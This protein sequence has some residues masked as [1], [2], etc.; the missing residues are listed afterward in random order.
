VGPLTLL[1]IGMS[2]GLLLGAVVARGLLSQQPDLAVAAVDARAA[3]L[4]TPS[5]VLAKAE[6]AP[7]P[8][9]MPALVEA[10]PA[11]AEHADVEHDQPP[12]APA[13]AD[14]APT[15][16]ATATGPTLDDVAPRITVDAHSTHVLIPLRGDGR[17]LRSYALSTP[18]LAVTLPHAQALAPLGNQRIV[19]GLVRRVWL[20]PEAPQ[21]VQVRIITRRAPARS[22][23]TFDEAGLP[24]VLAH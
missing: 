15:E 19:E 7:E 13:L 24:V 1:A 18:G 23:V 2:V 12:D 5:V 10:L 4:Q 17:D 8:E 14:D 20:L 9:P 16:D 11:D 22:S 3:A 6:A 21:G